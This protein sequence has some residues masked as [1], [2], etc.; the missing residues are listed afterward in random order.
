MATG[1][2]PFDTIEEILVG[3]YN[4]TDIEDADLRDLLAKMLILD[5]QKRARMDEVLAHP[6]LLM[7]DSKR[8]K[9]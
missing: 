2:M 3:R 7:R 9:K 5:P 1:S 6:W 4:D 8:A